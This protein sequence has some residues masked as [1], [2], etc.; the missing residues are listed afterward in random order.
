MVLECVYKEG[1]DPN[2]LDHLYINICLSVCICALQSFLTENQSGT[3]ILDLTELTGIM[4]V[5]GVFMLL[6]L[7]LFCF[8]S[9]ELFS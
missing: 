4:K 3:N 5:S 1:G 6:S 2:S 9:G 7:T 8:I